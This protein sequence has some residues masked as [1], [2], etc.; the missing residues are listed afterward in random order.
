MSL[1]PSPI[2][3]VLRQEG[4]SLIAGVDEAGRGPLAGPVFAAAV[5]LP[6]ESTLPPIL[7]SKKF[8]PGPREALYEKILSEAV[9]WHVSRIDH[10][11]IDEI[12]ILRATLKAMVEAVKNLSTTPEMILVD[13]SHTPF[14][15]SHSRA[16]KNGDSLSQCIGAASILAK[17]E[18]DRVM[19]EHHARYP[20]YG[21][22]RHKG[23]GTREHRQAIAE[24]GP[25]E[26]HR[27]TFRGVKEYL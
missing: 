9:T 27:R 15:D 22:N 19:K 2:D 13:G 23:Y 7:D 24:Y 25:C 17:V 10:D 8:S 26:I 16:V 18:R 5:I 20:H 21:F 12:N 1:S 6:E 14:V 3:E 4:Y 11:V